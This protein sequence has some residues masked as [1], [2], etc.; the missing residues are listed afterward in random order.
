MG[1]FPESEDWNIDF[2]RSKYLAILVVDLR[3]SLRNFFDQ[4]GHHRFYLGRTA[5][6][7]LGC[8]SGTKWLSR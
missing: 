1:L 4:V 3:P 5:G 6:K 7:D 2:T 8:P